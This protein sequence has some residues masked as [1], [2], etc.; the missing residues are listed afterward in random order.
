MVQL[1]GPTKLQTAFT[2]AGTPSGPDTRPLGHGPKLLSI[3]QRQKQDTARQKCSGGSAVLEKGWCQWVQ[4]L[5]KEGLTITSFRKT[6]LWSTE[7]GYSSCVRFAMKKLQDTEVPNAHIDAICLGQ[8]AVRS[9]SKR[10][11]VQGLWPPLHSGWGRLAPI[12]CQAPLSAVTSVMS[13]WP[14]GFLGPRSHSY[15]RSQVSHPGRS[16]GRG[17]GAR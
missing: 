17:G 14:L 12:P 5:T 15:Q 11:D 8:A 9:G 4:G 2:L 16:L 7:S 6:E 1:I 13:P 3:M 10:H